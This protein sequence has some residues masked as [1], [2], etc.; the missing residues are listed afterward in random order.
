MT[1][2]WVDHGFAAGPSLT[3]AAYLPLRQMKSEKP[4]R[5]C[6]VCG[7]GVKRAG[8]ARYCSG[9]CKYEASLGRQRARR[10]RLCLT[11]GA[12]IVG[13]GK[14][15]EAHL[16]YMARYLRARRDGVYPLPPRTGVCLRCGAPFTTK[17]PMKRFCSR[18]CQM[19]ALRPWVKRHHPK[20]RSWKRLE[21]AERDGWRC[22]IC[23]AAIDRRLKYPHPGSLSLDHIDPRGPHEPGN[24][25]AAHLACNVQA[26]AKVG[27]EIPEAG[28]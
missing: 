11:C 27:S 14:H 13:P 12:P 15:C 8:Q 18:L 28:R 5:L 22:G 24:W 19:R 3:R 4:G 23:H 26:G 1:G 2:G 10:R 7:G 17:S 6:P 9:R 21:I 16:T 20:N 25:Q